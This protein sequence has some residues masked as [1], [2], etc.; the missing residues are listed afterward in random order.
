[1]I[2]F[3][4]R[5]DHQVK[6][7]GFRIELGEVESVL[8]QHQLVKE[9]AV[10]IRED[11]FG[12]KRLAGYVVARSELGP[13]SDGSLEAR[14]LHRYLQNKLPDYMVPSV[15]TF[16]DKLPL[17][18]SGKLDRR[19]LPEPKQLSEQ[20]V[21]P[22]TPLQEKIAQIWQNV[23]GVERVGANDNFFEI[24][25]HSL[26]ALRV[27]NQ[28]R[29]LAGDWVSVALVLEAPT[30]ARFAELLE[31][32]YLIGATSTATAGSDQGTASEVKRPTLKPAP[33]RSS[34]PALLRVPWKA[35]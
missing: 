24:G 17:T 8:S 4:G 26:T 22:S 9:C 18:S 1:V 6:L 32:N 34:I 15:W 3:L 11:R 5:I 7:R 23:L 2:E 14:L 31:K 16:L 12:D 20:L 19:A 25:G 30:V 33:G 10:I 27:A 21:E 13:G 29:K 28:L 35:K